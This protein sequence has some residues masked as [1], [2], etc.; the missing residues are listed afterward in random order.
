MSNAIVQIKDGIGGVFNLYEDA[1]NPGFYTNPNLIGIA[2][3]TYEL[4]VNIDSKLITG[5]SFMNPR[6]VIDSLTFDQEPDFGGEEE[7]RY[8][9]TCHLT[10]PLNVVNFYRM[11]PFIGT[12]KEQIDGYMNW[13]DDVIDG[14][15]TGL[16]VFNVTYEKGD[17][18]TLELLSVD[19]PNFRYFTALRSSQG[20]EVPGNPKTNLS[21]E[22]VV[23]YFGA[24][25]KSESTIIIGE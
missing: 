9:I 2:G 20:G 24:Y 3:R 5:T 4:N 18:A 16:P 23:G 17:V 13:N 11:K 10:D 14:L 21:G 1:N 12:D 8:S 22:K 15:S 7:P 25:A 19:E 6:I